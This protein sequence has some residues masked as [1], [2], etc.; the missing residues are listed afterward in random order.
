MSL[1]GYPCLGAPSTQA[2]QAV[3]SFQQLCAAGPL[4][5]KAVFARAE[6]RG[7]RITGRD[8]PASFD[9]ATQ[10]LSPAG[11]PSLLLNVTTEAS[12]GEQRDTCG[13]AIADPTSDLAAAAQGWLGF[14]PT[15]AMALSAT[16]AALR[17]GDDW[18]SGAALTPAEFAKAKAEGRFYSIIVG[19]RGTEEANVPYPAF[20]MLLHVQP[21]QQAGSGH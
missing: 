20:V 4:S 11:G 12:H 5:P 2:Q 8:A 13:I 6:A 18:R 7:W 17:A 16:Y 21:M 9:P 10:R 3:T 15:F 14:A 19:N 1:A